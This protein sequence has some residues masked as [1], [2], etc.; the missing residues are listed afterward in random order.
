MNPLD[1]PAARPPRTS[2]RS[3]SGKRHVRSAAGEFSSAKSQTTP[4]LSNRDVIHFVWCS[5][6]TYSSAPPS[7]NNAGRHPARVGHG[8]AVFVLLG[9][10]RRRNPANLRLNPRARPPD[11]M[12]PPAR[13]PRSPA[14]GR[15]SPPCCLHIAA[16]EALR[17]SGSLY[18]SALRITTT[19]FPPPPVPLPRPPAQ[20]CLLTFTSAP[21]VAVP[22]GLYFLWGPVVMAARRNF[23]FRAYPH[24]GVWRT[25]VLD[26]YVDPGAHPGI[27]EYHGGSK[28]TPH[29]RSVSECL[30]SAVV[31]CATKLYF[32]ARIRLKSPIRS[33]DAK[34]FSTT[35][36]TS[37]RQAGSPRAISSSPAGPAAL[38]GAGGSRL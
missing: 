35:Q 9:P 37:R 17:C 19:F 30:A 29:T 1:T 16:L 5:V 6:S 21:A 18:P 36:A 13:S 4:A 2:Y 33:V 10:R 7:R 26:V 8:R 34:R 25:R 14:A 22:L 28:H 15:L 32:R 24:A 12:R 23:P 3:P 31:M 20:G 11:A 27:E 38:R